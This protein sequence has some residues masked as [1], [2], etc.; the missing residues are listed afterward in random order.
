[1]AKE[2]NNLLDILK[3][4]CI[5]FV[6]VTHFRWEEHERLKYL[7]PY[8]IDMAV[9][10]FMIIS[11]YVYSKSYDR[12]N[13][14]T[15]SMVYSVQNIMKTFIRYTVPFSTAVSLEMLWMLRCNESFDVIPFIVK[16][17]GGSGSYYYPIMIQFM[18]LFPVIYFLVKRQGLYGF[19]ICGIINIVYE[20]LQTSYGMSDECYRLLVFRYILVISYGCYLAL[21]EPEAPAIRTI[22]KVSSFLTGLIFITA[23][24][25]WNYSPF[26]ITK[27]AGTSWL[28]CLYVLPIFS[29]ILTKVKIKCGLVE[30][31]GKASF[32][33]FLVQMVYFWR[34]VE[35]AYTLINSRMIQLVFSIVFCIFAGVIFYYI[36]K[37]ITNKLI[38]LAN[39]HLDKFMNYNLKDKINQ[40]APK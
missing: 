34:F 1:M 4:V 27:W 28:A 40:V 19:I 22:W 36:E 11:G 31:I 18:F 32:N 23:Y 20:I 21:K 10:I 5:I 7:F 26:I 3:G 24:C 17:G 37:P 39:I 12:K 13:I 33:I 29:F 6:I 9:P 2:R 30:T 14:C 8:W 25:Y 38:R 35:I 15:F 16:G